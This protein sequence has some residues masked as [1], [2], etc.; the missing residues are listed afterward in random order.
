MMLFMSEENLKQIDRKDLPL[1]YRL[2]LKIP[3]VSLTWFPDIFQGLFWAI[4]VPVFLLFEIFLNIIFIGHFPFPLSVI[5][6]GL[7]PAIVFILVAKTMLERFLNW[8]NLNVGH[9]HEW[10]VEKTIREYKALLERQPSVKNEQ[11]D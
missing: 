3:I 4:A 6:I 7:I 5:L 8:W 9:V 10:N 1:V 2:L 11:E